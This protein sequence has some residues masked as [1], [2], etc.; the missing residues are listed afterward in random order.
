MDAE[1]GVVANV[2]ETDHIFRRGAKAW[3]ANWFSGGERATWIAV[4]RGGRVVEKVAP[5]H[6]FDNFRCAWVPDHLQQRIVSP[7][8]TID[9]MK[10]KAAF[11]NER[12]RQE[13]DAH[14][15]RKLEFYESAS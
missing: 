7:R 3:L 1:Y 6:R 5:L 10:V 2:I 9:E 13:R 12:A 14:P 15:N 8:G 11:W 4:S